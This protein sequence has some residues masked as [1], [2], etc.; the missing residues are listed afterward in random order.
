MELTAR[1]RR[2]IHRLSG[3]QRKRV[4]IGVELLTKPTLFFLDEP[5]SGLDPGLETRMMELMRKVADQGRTVLLVTHATQN[6]TLCDKVVFMA[7]GGYLAFFGPPQEALEYFGVETFAEIYDTA[8]R[9]RSAGG[10]GGAVRGIA[11]PRESTWTRASAGRLPRRAAARTAAA[12]RPAGPET[13]A[14]RVLS[15]F[16]T[17]TARYIAMI[18]KD[19]RNLIILL[20]QAPIIGV[21]LG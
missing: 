20:L 12:R 18:L 1:K 8:R 9:S 17:L 10:V 11:L 21:L 2:P 16:R 13:A 4:S 15:Q 6:V 7:P 19:S 3:G 14:R 5:T